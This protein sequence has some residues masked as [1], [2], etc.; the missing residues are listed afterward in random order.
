MSLKGSA[1]LLLKDLATEPLNDMVRGRHGNEG[2]TL[3]N[4]AGWIT[5]EMG[6]KHELDRE[7]L[8]LGC[9]LLARD[10]SRANVTLFVIRPQNARRAY[11]HSSNPSLTHPLSCRK[12]CSHDQ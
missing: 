7:T 8:K 3:G 10:D 2:H 4:K 5:R 9:L 1:L 12:S 6:L 11:H